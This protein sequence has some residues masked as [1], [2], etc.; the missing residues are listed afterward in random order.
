[1]SVLGIGIDAVDIGRFRTALARTP[2]IVTRVFTDDERRYAERQADP[3]QRFAVR[4]AAKEAVMKA[5]GIGIGGVRLTEIEVVRA[6]GGRPAVR[7]HGSAAERAAELG[8]GTWQLSLTHTDLVAQA[9]AVAL[10][11]SDS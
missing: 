9:V 5:M 7:L 1:M 11:G 6:D 2:G 10:A 3:T 4:F 8:V